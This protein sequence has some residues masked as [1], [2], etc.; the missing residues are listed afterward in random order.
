MTLICQRTELFI[1]EIMFIGNLLYLCVTFEWQTLDL[2][3]L[4]SSVIL[5]EPIIRCSNYGNMLSSKSKERN[6]VVKET[7]RSRHWYI[8]ERIQRQW[9]KE[10]AYRHDSMEDNL[11]V[12]LRRV[13]VWVSSTPCGRRTYPTLMQGG[14]A[15]CCLNLI[16]HP[17]LI[18]IGN[19]T[20]S[21]SMEE[22]WI[23]EG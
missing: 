21:I 3:F 5:T 8:M 12:H 16:C 4:H 19:L 18:P 2:T 11:K 9:G 20:H 1:W 15:W 7:I 22:E 17:L 23:G 6:L 14:G 10:S 13:K